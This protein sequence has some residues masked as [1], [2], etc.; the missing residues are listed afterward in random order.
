LQ[1]GKWLTPAEKA[2][3]FNPDILVVKRIAMLTAA[4]CGNPQI[5]DAAPVI[6]SGDR[7]L[8]KSTLGI[9]VMM[10]HAKYMNKFYGIKI[11]MKDWLRQKIY[12]TRAPNAVSNMYK[13]FNDMRMF[14][15][16][17]FEGLNQKAMFEEVIK[18]AIALNATTSHHMLN[19]FCF[20]WPW[21]ATHPILEVSKMWD[22]KYDKETGY[23]Y[24]SP[25]F[26]K[27]KDPYFI[28]EIT[29]A[30]RASTMKWAMKYVDSFIMDHSTFKAPAK[31]YE[32]Y[33]NLKTAAHLQES[34]IEDLSNVI[35]ETDM[36]EFKEILAEVKAQRMTMADTD[37]KLFFRKK[38]YSRRTIVNKIVEFWSFHDNAQHIAV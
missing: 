11:D 2:R 33:D 36:L 26:M 10:Y 13:L 35:H 3:L 14:D 29:S 37:L 20:S 8:G 1:I 12:K 27:G 25:R 23:L 28:G 32:E 15:E 7:R 4:L 16:A 9:N 34:E 24:C 6:L 30:K 5:A 31:V 17:Y 19:L 38:G 18:I 21:R 22:H